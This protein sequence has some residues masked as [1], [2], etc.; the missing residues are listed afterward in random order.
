LASHASAVKRAKQN[1]KR[2]LR[3]LHIKTTMKSSVKKVRE[4][5][6][7]KDLEGAQKALAKAVPLIQKGHTK[8]VYHRNTTSRKVSRLTREVN[9]LKSK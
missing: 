6:E 7:K 8:G 3:N 9:T 4:A 1:E 2:A 5:I